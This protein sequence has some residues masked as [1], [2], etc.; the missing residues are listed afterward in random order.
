MSGRAITEAE[1][2]CSNAAK[3]LLKMDG[4]ESVVI[5]MTSRGELDG[6]GYPTTCAYK[7]GAGNAFAQIG[8]VIDW[9]NS[10]RRSSFD[11]D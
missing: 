1:Q 10:Q 7:A 2:K 8:S 11:E 4:V 6:E 3:N 9:L 5:I